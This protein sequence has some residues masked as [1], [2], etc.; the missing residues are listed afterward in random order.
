MTFCGS[1]RLLCLSTA[2]MLNADVFISPPIPTCKG[3]SWE[4][5][6]SLIFRRADTRMQN[7]Q[8]S[9]PRIPQGSMPAHLDPV[10]RAQFPSGS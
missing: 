10:N 5:S 8:S 6:V 7:T 2:A 4:S 1:P 3:R 9:L